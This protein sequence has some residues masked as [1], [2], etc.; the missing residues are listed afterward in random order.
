MNGKTRKRWRKRLIKLCVWVVA[1]VLPAGA[2]MLFVLPGLTASVTS[3]YNSYTA[4]IG[5]IS[6]ALSFSGSISVKNS[7]ILR[8]SDSATVRQIYVNEEQSVKSGERLMRLSN[9]ETIKASFDGKVNEIFVKIDDS[10]TANADLIQ[11]VDFNNM[12]ISMRVDEYDISSVFVGQECSVLVLA[13][14]RAI[15]SKITHINRVSSA[16]ATSASGSVAYYTVTAE[17]TVAGD[18]LPG[19][20][21]TVTIPQE[22][23]IDAVI[24]NKEALSFTPRNSAYVLMYNQDNE[25]ERVNVEIGVDNDNFVEIKD[26]IKD[27]D[28]VYIIAP[29]NTSR[30]GLFNMFGGMQ[31][32]RTMY[33]QPRSFDGGGNYQNFSGEARFPRG[34]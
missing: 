24:I 20:Q 13:F 29:E 22:E 5:S 25:L 23:A 31:Q 9:G 15:G 33:S 34:N 3:T 27:G 1:L 18:V 17:L 14:N 26:G 19:M 6:N 32:P 30:R 8:S 28:V 10:V 21:V 2:F 4:R 12:K 11:I 7:E 16:S